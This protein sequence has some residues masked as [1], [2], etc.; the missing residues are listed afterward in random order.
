MNGR[1]RRQGLKREGK[2]ARGNG[3]SPLAFPIEGGGVNINTSPTSSAPKLTSI[4]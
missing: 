2:L 1:K 4:L 3:W